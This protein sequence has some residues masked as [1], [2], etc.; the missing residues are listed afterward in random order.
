[1][2]IIE[3]K[4]F[5]A[6]RALY[7]SRSLEV[8]GCRFDGPADGESALKESSDIIADRCF[9][10][11]RYPLW[12]VH[13]LKVRDSEMTSAC[14]AALWYSDDIEITNTKMHGIK[15]LRECGGVTVKKLRH[16]FA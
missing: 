8:R 5:D 12:H 3:N 10:N 9:F 7:G 11:L 1:M 4:T 15:A 6:E 16:C 13:G 2:E 14:R